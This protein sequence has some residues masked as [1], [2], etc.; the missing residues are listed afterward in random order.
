M[1][2]G[3]REVRQ[4]TGK[5]CMQCSHPGRDQKTV[6]RERSQTQGA[7]SVSCGAIGD[8][9]RSGKDTVDSSKRIA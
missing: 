1:H 4:R 9:N 6:V 3:K 2:H 5:Q 7:L 8:E